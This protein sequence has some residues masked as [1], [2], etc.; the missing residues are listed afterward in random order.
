MLF[1]FFKWPVRLLVAPVA[2]AIQIVI[3]MAVKKVINENVME[4][5][6]NGKSWQ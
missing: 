6:Q 4:R 5:L 3:I 2:S 1:R